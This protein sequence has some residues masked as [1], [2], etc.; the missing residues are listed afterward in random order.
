VKTHSPLAETESVRRFLSSFGNKIIPGFNIYRTDF[1]LDFLFQYINEFSLQRHIRLG[2]AHPIPGKKNSFIGLDD[3]EKVL[4]RL[5]S[6]RAMFER[7]RVKPGLDCGYPMCKFTDEQLAWLY[8]FTGGKNEFG[9]GPVID[10]GPDMSVWPCFPLSSFH[11]KS[12]FEFDSVKEI[13][14]YYMRI[15]NSIRIEAGG[16][17]EE[18][19]SC[20]FRE[21]RHCQGGCVAHSLARFKKEEPLRMKEVYY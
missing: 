21:E 13:H 16:I 9:C 8:R 2:I 20:V 3:M 15:H 4:D 7:F 17:F 10:I 1:Q 6:Y 11:K 18:C 12:V 14:D 5:F 19:D